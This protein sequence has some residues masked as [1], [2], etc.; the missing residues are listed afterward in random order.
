MIN[1]PSLYNA[2]CRAQKR[3]IKYEN[4]I[5]RSSYY[6]YCY[7]RDILKGQFELG[8]K[9]IAKDPYCSYLYACEA[10]GR[11]FILGERSIIGSYYAIYYENHFDCEL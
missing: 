8:E 3:F 11:R 10:L 7:A 4:I 5:A 1:I 6:S 9:Q 2:S